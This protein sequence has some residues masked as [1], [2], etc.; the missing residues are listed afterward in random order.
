[1]LTVAPSRNAHA[2]RSDDAV[3][4]LCGNGDSAAA[5]ALGTTQLAAN[6]KPMKGR[7]IAS[8]W[9]IPPQA[10]AAASRPAA[11]ARRVPKRSIPAMPRRITIR[12]VNHAPA[13]WP[14]MT[15]A[16][17]TLYSRAERPRAFTS[18]KAELVTK[19]NIPTCAPSK[20]QNGAMNRRSR[21]METNVRAVRE[22]E[23]AAAFCG[24][25]SFSTTATDARRQTATVASSPNVPRQPHQTSNCAPINGAAIGTIPKTTIILASMRAAC[26]WLCRSL[27]M[28][29]AMTGPLDMPRPCTKRQ[30]VIPAT[31][32]AP[33]HASADARYN[34][35]PQSRTGFLPKRSERGPHASWPAAMPKKNVVI[36][37]CTSATGAPNAWAIAGSVGT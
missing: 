24:T 8:Q 1:M 17:R 5:V 15:T 33:R 20:T 16:N 29:R 23:I 10:S 35:R 21:R 11:Q 26:S 18:T 3:P 13:I 9:P 27:T 30:N 14:I 7:T 31:D 28:V 4:A 2:P 12:L 34:A 36:V 22:G 37:N 19:A 6:M 32:S 25:V